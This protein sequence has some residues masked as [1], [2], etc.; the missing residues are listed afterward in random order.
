MDSFFDG[1]HDILKDFSIP[2]DLI[3]LF[4]CEELFL[5]PYVDKTVRRSFAD[6][7]AVLQFCTLFVQGIFHVDACATLIAENEIHNALINPS[8]DSVHI[9]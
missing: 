1:V 4:Q 2:D 6:E 7:I 3:T 8:T 9:D 5:V